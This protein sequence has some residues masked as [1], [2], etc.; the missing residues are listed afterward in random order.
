MFYY[1]DIIYLIL[2]IFSSDLLKQGLVFCTCF[3]FVYMLNYLYNFICVYSWSISLFVW[4]S[5]NCELNNF[6][7][8]CNL[9]RLQGISFQMSWQTV[10]KMRNRDIRE[11]Y[12]KIP[13]T[14][15]KACQVGLCSG[16]MINC[17]AVA[18]ISLN[19][20]RRKIKGKA[21][22]RIYESDAA[23]EAEYHS[24]HFL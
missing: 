22:S 23:Y 15:S 7:V 16:H 9:V 4:N 18:S 17:R 6:N 12:M 19:R 3:D 1:F 11:K 2:E 8:P 10:H 14:F 24:S 20:D 5:T 21:L 13:V